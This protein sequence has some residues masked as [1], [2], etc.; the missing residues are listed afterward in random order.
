MTNPYE[1]PSSTHAGVARNNALRR[2]CICGALGLL[3]GLAWAAV[4]GPF[5]DGPPS[6]ALS[7][8]VYS[9]GLALTGFVV[10]W[11]NRAPA[12]IGALAGVGILVVWAIV[13][14]PKDGWIVIWLVAFGGS[15]LI[16]GTI[17]GCIWL[18]IRRRIAA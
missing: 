10:G 9:S 3:V 12:G 14:G 2:G 1:P 11:I 5:T 18:G 15:G 8:V 7:F 13:V 4:F 16:W 17:I 6:L